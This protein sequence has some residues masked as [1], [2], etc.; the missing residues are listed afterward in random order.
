[1]IERR[2]HR[3]IKV[4]KKFWSGESGNS[5]WVGRPCL[6]DVELTIPIGKGGAEGQP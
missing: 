4:D 1:M 3:M 2:K 5:S 6:E